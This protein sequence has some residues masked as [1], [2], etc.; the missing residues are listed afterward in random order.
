MSKD[1]L[2]SLM[3]SSA[4]R[5]AVQLCENHGILEN[6]PIESMLEVKTQNYLKLL[7][8]VTV[9][10]EVF[11]IAKKYHGRLPMAIGTGGS[12]RTISETLNQTGIGKYFDVIIAADDVKNHKPAPDTFLECAKL[13]GVEPS[14][15][16]VFEDGDP[17]LEAAIAG[18]M[19]AT[20]IRHWVSP[21]W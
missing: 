17:G 6:M 13:L 9:I 10:D 8:K 2:R 4:K 5:I 14:D 1:F 18:G 19:I 16:E 20:D 12:R 15:C 11:D 21:T 3:G 7:P